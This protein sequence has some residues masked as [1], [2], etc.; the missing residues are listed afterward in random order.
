MMKG[1][2]TLLVC[3]LALGFLCLTGAKAQAEDYAALTINNPT[4]STVYYQLRWGDGEWVSY[5]LAPHYYRCHSHY[6]DENNRAPAPYIQFDNGVGN[7]KNY[8][9]RFY[10]ANRVNYYSGKLYNFAWSG[11]YL[12]LYSR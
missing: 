1:K 3:G 8:H 11:P 9:L 7:V 5:S 12:D 6:L 10:G 2:K 4:S